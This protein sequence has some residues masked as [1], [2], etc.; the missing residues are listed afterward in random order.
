MHD[1]AG[2]GLTDHLTRLLEADRSLIDAKGCDAYPHQIALLKGH[3]RVFDLLWDKSD[4]TTERERKHV[5]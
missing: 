5:A 1:A 2:L 4:D 3:Q